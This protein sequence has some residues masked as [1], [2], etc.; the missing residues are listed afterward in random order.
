MRI[1][2]MV[3]R[4]AIPA[5][6]IGMIVSGCGSDDTQA[7]S[8]DIGVTNDINPKDPSELRD[9]GNLRMSISSFPATFNYNHVDM[10]SDVATVIDPLLP[11]SFTSDAAGILA[12]NHDYYTDIKLTNTNPQQVTY[13]INPKAVWSDGTPITWEDLKAEA[14]ALAGAAR[15]FQIASPSG[16]DRVDRVERGVDD[17]Q[18][19][20]TFSTPYAEWKGQFSPLYPK[21]VNASPQAFNDLDRS[22]LAVSSGPFV[23]TNIDRTQNRITLSRNPKWWGATPKLDTITFTVLDSSALLPGI[24]NNELDYASM[25]GLSNVTAAR[26]AANVVVRHT[27]EPTWSHLTFNGAQ[28]SVLADPRVRVAITKAIDRQAIVNATENGLV[29][30]PKPLDNHIYMAG[31]KGYQDNS[32]PSAFDPKAA[33]AQL[34]ALGWKLD[35]DVREKDGRKLVLRDVMYQQDLWVNVAQIVQQNLA[36]IG[37]KVDIQTYPGQGLFTDVIDP[38]NFDIAQFSWV[39]N[40][41]PLGA[42]EQI[43]AYDPNNRQGNDGRIGTP[44]LNALIK[45]TM[46]ELD[47]DKAIQLANRCDKMIWEEGFSLPLNQ[48]PGNYAV[49]AN[50]ANIGAFG[51]ASADWTKVGFLK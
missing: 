22:S 9:G 7:G 37:V 25:S 16:F 49:R 32:A 5:I 51:M 24:Q 42:L 2:S 17:R 43:Y 18:A 38:G 45:Q 3:T 28:G 48:R 19:I 36:A 47:P 26:S 20:V 33:A 41:Y 30:N 44:E 23:I 13:T 6:A 27:P 21:A 14:D 34:D 11:T 1:R 50:L 35:G 31:Q 15:G 10:D 29:D 46:A 4:V 40:P 12:V 8:S 39:G